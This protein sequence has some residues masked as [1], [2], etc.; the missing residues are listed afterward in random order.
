V[1]LVLVLVLVSLAGW[2]LGPEQ[3]KFLKVGGARQEQIKVKLRV[4]AQLITFL[5][6]I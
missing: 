3:N 4:Q 1:V 2:A 5:L 6:L